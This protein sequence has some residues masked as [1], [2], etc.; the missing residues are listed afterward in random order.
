MSHWW[1]VLFDATRVR[2]SGSEPVAAN[3]RPSLDDH[4]VSLPVVVFLS[5]GIEK[6]ES[7]GLSANHN[8]HRIVIKYLI[9]Y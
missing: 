3:R 4:P 1:L 2:R 7:V 8:R 9:N 5:G 6:S